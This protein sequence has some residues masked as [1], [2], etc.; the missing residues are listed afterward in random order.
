MISVP[1]A[2]CGNNCMKYMSHHYAT[3][4]SAECQLYCNKTGR[5]KKKFKWNRH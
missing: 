4:L 5:K 3:H 1:Q 2:Y